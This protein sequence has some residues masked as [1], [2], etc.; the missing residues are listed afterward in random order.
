MVLTD[1]IRKDEK[2]VEDVF[3]CYRDLLEDKS[4]TGVLLNQYLEDRNIKKTK[5]NS[6]FNGLQLDKD[7]LKHIYEI[8]PQRFLNQ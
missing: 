2:Y 5:K 6:V 7:T 4:Y 1:D 3:A 8:N